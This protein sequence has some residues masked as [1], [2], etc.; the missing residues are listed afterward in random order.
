[1]EEAIES[2]RTA[3]EGRLIATNPMPMWGETADIGNTVA[4]LCSQNA[5]YLTGVVIPVDG[6]L[7]LGK[8][9]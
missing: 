9:G 2:T 4:F 1:M 5:R 6:G 8:L 7:H 3:I